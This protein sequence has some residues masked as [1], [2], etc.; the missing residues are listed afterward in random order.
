MKIVRRM[1]KVTDV[2]EYAPTILSQLTKQKRDCWSV[3][4]NERSGPSTLMT[5]D[6]LFNK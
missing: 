3:V 5:I 4:K 2:T 6:S 1:I